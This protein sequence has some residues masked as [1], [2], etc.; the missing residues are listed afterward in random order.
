LNLYTVSHYKLRLLEMKSRFKKIQII[1]VIAISLAIPASSAYICYYT[2]AAADFLSPNLNFET[3]DQEF[4]FSAYE[5]ELK[6]FVPGN[7]LNEFHLITYLSGRSFNFL[8]PLSSYD[9]ET[10]I[11]R[12]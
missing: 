6:V 1:L 3:F 7:F 10:L 11:L 12:C 4:L 8:S 9:E 5:N 2:V